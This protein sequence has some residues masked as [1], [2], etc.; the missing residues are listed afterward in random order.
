MECFFPAQ[1]RVRVRIPAFNAPSASRVGVPDGAPEVK[2]NWETGQ[3]S[4]GKSVLKL[5]GS[6]EEGPAPAAGLVPGPDTVWPSQNGCGAARWAHFLLAL[7]R[8]DRCPRLCTGLHLPG[9]LVRKAV[10]YEGKLSG[11]EEEWVRS[12]CAE[13]QVIVAGVRE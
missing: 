6:A 4:L 3:G 9:E 5:G 12:L 10:D 2:G 1:E 8:S 13:S 11:A 7:H